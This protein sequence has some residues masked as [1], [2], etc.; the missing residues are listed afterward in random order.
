MTYLRLSDYANDIALHEPFPASPLKLSVQEQGMLVDELLDELRSNLVRFG[1]DEVEKLDSDS[2][3][4]LLDSALTLLAPASLSEDGI[5]RLN[6]LLQSEL[7]DRQLVQVTT[8][9]QD[10][11]MNAGATD[12]IL[13]QGDI[14]TLNVD[15]IVNAANNQLLG[16]FIPQHKC[17]DNVIHSRA[18]VQLR[19]DCQIIM[20]KQQ[21]LEATGM[22][23]VTRAYNLPSEYVIHTVGPIVQSQVT[24]Q[25]QELL[26]GCYNSALDIAAEV[27]A[28]RSLAFCCISTGVFGYPIERAAPVAV[29]AVMHWLEQNPDQLDCVI[30]NVFS[31]KDKQAYEQVFAALT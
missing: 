17:I 2:K 9:A 7:H 6:R 22:A 4:I 10:P 25:H 19:S 13:W 21:T 12:I 1:I 26:T 16:C 20:H 29:A 27:S 14:T 3:R 5:Q 18:G 31:D 8:L 23:K 11:V 28:I 24:K 15:A 30:F